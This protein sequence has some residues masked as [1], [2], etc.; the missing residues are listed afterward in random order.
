MA[1]V[2]DISRGA[3]VKAILPEGIVTI[4]GVKWIGTVAMEATYKDSAGT[5]GSKPV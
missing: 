1:Q 2:E 4:L 3:V 5:L